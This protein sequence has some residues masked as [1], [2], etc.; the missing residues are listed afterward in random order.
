MR[1]LNGGKKDYYDYISGIYGID[2]DI[3]YDRREGHVFRRFEAGEEYFMTREV[4]QDKAP[5]KIS[6]LEWIDGKP[7]RVFDMVGR[8]LY[9]VIEA[10]Y[11]QYLFRVDR[12]LFQH[13]VEIVPVLIEKK[14]LTE[15][16]SKHPL[17]LI[18][19]DYRG[20]WNEAPS[21]R[22][23]MMDKEIPN[24]I[25][26]DTWVTSYINPEELYNNIYDY[27]ISIREPKIEDNR[28]DIQKLESKGFDKVTSFRNPINKRK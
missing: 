27:L 15:K 19:V 7:K 18:P 11:V 2:E 26:K 10:G 5:S 8:R 24:P 16:K 25:L 17:S 9:F 22:S 4:W 1:I 14:R 13:E 28:N 12:N 21:I 6:Y 23:Y 3:T 20:W